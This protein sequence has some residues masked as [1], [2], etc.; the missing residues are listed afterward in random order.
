MQEYKFTIPG[1]LPG[2]NKFINAERN[3]KYKAAKAISKAKAL[4]S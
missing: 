4:V 2:L 1:V 3:N